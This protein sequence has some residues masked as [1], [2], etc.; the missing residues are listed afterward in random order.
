M[1]ARSC[2]H[3]IPSFPWFVRVVCLSICVSFIIFD[4]AY[5]VMMCVVVVVVVVLILFIVSVWS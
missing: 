4:E 1:N 3:V 5:R 2:V